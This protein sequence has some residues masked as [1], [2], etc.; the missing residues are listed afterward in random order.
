MNQFV[1]V[2][3][4]EDEVKTEDRWCWWMVLPVVA[5]GLIVYQIGTGAMTSVFDESED[6]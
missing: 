3:D 6:D 2:H 5:L 4:D 1:P